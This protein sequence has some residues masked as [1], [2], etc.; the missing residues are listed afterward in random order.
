MVANCTPVH[1]EVLSKPWVPCT[2]F[3]VGLVHS[4]RPLPEHSMKYLRATKGKRLMSA[5]ENFFGVSTMPWTKR[6]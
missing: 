1:S 3:R 2:V 6:K 4:V 5:T